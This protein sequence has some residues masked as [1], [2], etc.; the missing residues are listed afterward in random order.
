MADGESEVVERFKTFFFFS[1]EGLCLRLQRFVRLR[2][3][4]PVIENDEVRVRFVSSSVS[5]ASAG[6]VTR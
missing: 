1:Y 3:G 6:R 2:G 5:H 4:R